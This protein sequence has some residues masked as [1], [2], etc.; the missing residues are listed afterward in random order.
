MFDTSHRPTVPFIKEKAALCIMYI[1][2][3]PK[4]RNTVATCYPQ[5]KL[6]SNRNGKNTSTTNRM[7]KQH[8]Q[9]TVAALGLAK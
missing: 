7:R 3:N 6:S 5:N 4:P 8:K 9:S 2:D 1:N